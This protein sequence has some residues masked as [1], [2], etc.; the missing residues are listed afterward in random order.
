MKKILLLSASIVCLTI[1]AHGSENGT[2]KEAVTNVKKST[3]LSDKLNDVAKAT[4]T[5]D[6]FDVLTYRLNLKVDV[7]LLPGNNMKQINI[8]RQRMN[9][10][11]YQ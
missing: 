11:N 5:T 7:H 3:T 9:Y 10:V 2:P 4:I 6:F 1:N 8:K